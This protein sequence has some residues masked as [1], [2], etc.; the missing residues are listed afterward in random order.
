MNNMEL[1]KWLSDIEKIY[2]NLIDKAKEES[3]TE[4]QS[5]IDEEKKDV[6]TTLKKEQESFDLVLKGFSKEIKDYLENFEKKDDDEI[7]KIKAI[8][9]N[10]KNKL[11]EISLEKLGYV[12]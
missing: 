12:F 11:I 2:G 10:N 6:E 4:I 1:F 7:K 5:L 8:Y 3:I 9:Q